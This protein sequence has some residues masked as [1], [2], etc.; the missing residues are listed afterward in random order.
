VV[1]DDRVRFDVSLDAVQENGLKLS[2]ALLSV[3]HSVDGAKP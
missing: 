3:A 2:A 1:V